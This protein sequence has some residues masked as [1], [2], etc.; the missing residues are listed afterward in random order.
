MDLV[1][2]LGTG[3]RWE[4]NELR[5]ALR[6]AE[7]YINKLG[8]VYI[9]GERPEWITNVT[10]IPAVDRPGIEW[11]EFN[12]MQKVLKACALKQLSRE[13]IF[14][15]DDHFLLSP[16]PP[17]PYYC[18]GTLESK[19]AARRK[20]DHYYYSMNNTRNALQA[21]QRGDTYFD[22]HAPIIYNKNLFRDVVLSYDWLAVPYGYVIKSLYC[23]SLDIKGTQ[24]D[25]LKVRERV[26]CF[27]LETLTQH[28][29]YFS[30]SD[31]AVSQDLD[32]YLR[33]LYP[34][35]SKYEL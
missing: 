19:L 34:D 17:L 12:I 18:C 29:K 3:S 4:D 22:V 35:K 11:K 10:Y 30:I 32:I 13:F 25:D 26:N 16:M 8:N 7:K 31:E 6:S 9:I 14:M 20:Q 15:N 27:Q 1:I 21:R 24:D 28:R 5:F 2:P 33:Y 23:N